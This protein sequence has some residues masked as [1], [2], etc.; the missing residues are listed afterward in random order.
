MV[1]RG[2][3]RVTFYTRAGCHLCEEAKQALEVARRRVRFQLEVVD[4][5]QTAGLRA[6]YNEE[7]PVIAINGKKAFKHRLTADDFLKRLAART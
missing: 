4:I 2:E 7:V 1:M 5:D 3:T 6:L